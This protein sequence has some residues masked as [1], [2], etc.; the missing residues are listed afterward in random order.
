MNSKKEYDMAMLG[1]G[2]TGLSLRFVVSGYIVYLAWKILGASLDGS[3]PIPEWG[4][5]L[6]FAVFAAAAV[7]FC[8]FAVKKYL[9]TRKAAA[10]PAVSQQRNEKE[11]AFETKEKDETEN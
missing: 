6:I 3:S 5:W 1:K 9:D 11:D 10:L 7:A 2:L 8:V 4:S